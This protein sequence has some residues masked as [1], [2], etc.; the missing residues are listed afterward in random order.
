MNARVL[1]AHF[2]AP[3]RALLIPQ[4]RALRDRDSHY[5]QKTLLLIN[6]FFLRKGLTEPLG[7]EP[8]SPGPKPGGIVRYH[9]AP[10]L[11]LWAVLLITLFRTTVAG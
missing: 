7:F 6:L 10:R 3:T 5:H 9:T 11:M 8:R 2:L 4:F 1:A